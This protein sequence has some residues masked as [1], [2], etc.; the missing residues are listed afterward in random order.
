MLASSMMLARFLAALAILLLTGVQC[1]SDA[2]D[3]LSV[4]RARQMDAEM[5]TDRLLTL[6]GSTQVKL[7]SVAD[8]SVET[9]PSRIVRENQQYKRY[10]EVD[11]RGP[12]RM[13]E[14]FLKDALEEFSTPPG[15]SLERDDSSFFTEDAGRAFGWVLLGTIVLVFLATAA[16]FESWRLPGVVLLSVPT[17]LVGVAAA[18][19]LA[20]DLV[21]AE[22]AFIG[23]VLLVG[24]AANDSILLVD[25]YRHLRTARPHGAIGPI[26]RLALRERLRPMWTTTLSTCVAMLLLVFPQEEAFWTG[27]AVTVTGGLLAATLLAPLATVAIVA[28]IDE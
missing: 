12:H 9:V 13:G 3:A 10:V 21:F 28:I 6:A 14:A 25:R 26:V 19:L 1:T 11:Y 5:L 15:Y 18:F 17:A 24:I 4:E 16:V 2:P 7:K 20:G 23:S 8:Y 27:M 22:G